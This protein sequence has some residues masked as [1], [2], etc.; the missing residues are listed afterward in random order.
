MVVIF[1]NNRCID[2]THEKHI[3]TYF[4]PTPHVTVLGVLESSDC[5]NN[6]R[7]TTVVATPS[8]WISKRVLF[9]P[10]PCV[11]LLGSKHEA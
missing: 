6:G 7:L 1:R 3:T 4:A 11:I 2:L 9:R 10:V 5:V 8:A